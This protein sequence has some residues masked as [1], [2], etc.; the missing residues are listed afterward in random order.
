MSQKG[1]KSFQQLLLFLPQREATAMLR[2]WSPS[3]YT[4]GQTTQEIHFPEPPSLCASELENA[5]QGSHRKSES[6]LSQLLS[7]DRHRTDRQTDTH[8]PSQIWGSHKSERATANHAWPWAGRGCGS[9]RGPLEAQH[10]RKSA[11]SAAGWD[12]PLV[13]PQ[14]SS[15]PTASRWTLNHQALVLRLSA[16]DH[17]GWMM[18]FSR[19]VMPDSLRPHGLPCQESMSTPGSPVLHYLQE[20]ALTHVHWV[21]DAIQGL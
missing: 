1:R 12:W 16:P 21:G 18:L 8:T 10:H 11:P 17:Q 13:L 5:R 7:W 2:L 20:F 9:Q 6:Q 14:E 4:T 3:L 15:A 19:S